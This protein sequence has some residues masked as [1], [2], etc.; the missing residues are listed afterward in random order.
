M[1]TF[2]INE[3]LKTL[4]IWDKKY[5]YVMHESHWLTSEWSDTCEKCLK[6]GNKP[7]NETITVTASSPAKPEMM[8]LNETFDLYTSALAELA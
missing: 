7:L 6:S 4:N 2:D 5:D 1:A 3:W 8:S